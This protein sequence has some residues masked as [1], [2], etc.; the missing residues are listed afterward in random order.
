MEKIMQISTLEDMSTSLI[1]DLPT[2]T[3]G[4]IQTHITEYTFEGEEGEILIEEEDIKEAIQELEKMELGLHTAFLCGKDMVEC[5][6]DDERN[7]FVFWNKKG[8]EE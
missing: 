4:L 2:L 8:E 6:F 3:E 7:D 1:E 5:A